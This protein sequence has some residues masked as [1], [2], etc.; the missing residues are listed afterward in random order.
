MPLHL[1]NPH[2]VLAA[3]ETRPKDVSEVR[4][5]TDRPSGA[6]ADVVQIAEEHR[7]PV[8]YG[9]ERRE[10]RRR[11]KA[12][13]AK[14][15]GRTGAGEVVVQPRQSVEVKNL[16]SKVK[17]WKEGEPYGVWLALDCLQDPH[18]VGA[19]FRS[20]AFFGVQGIIVTKDRS[21]PLNSTVYDVA[22][23]G[24]DDVPFALETNL[25]RTLET[26]KSAGLWVLGTSEHA[27][28]DLAEVDRDRHWLL[29]VGN[30][31]KG[32]RR[33]TLENCDAVCRLTPRGR[34]TSLNVSVA[35]GILIAS[36]S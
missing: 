13:A 26:A 35:T 9:A 16:F 12:G 32:L 1:R 5:T 19:I 18:N 29:V 24:L 11:P 27:E 23:G 31:E 33:R 6:W 3:L 15:G 25:S 20:A 4:I 36:L 2:S 10:S 8:I 22:S 21:A 17:T 14:E 30:E 28:T 7:I 34:V